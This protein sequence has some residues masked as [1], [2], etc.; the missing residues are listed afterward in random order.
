MYYFLEKKGGIGKVFSGGP[1]VG[2][3]YSFWKRGRETPPQ[4]PNLWTTFHQINVPLCVLES[5]P[6]APKQVHWGYQPF[7]WIC[8]VAKMKSIPPKR[9]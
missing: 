3:S 1:V 4:N 6:E 8:S 5:M 2:L 9:W 7:T